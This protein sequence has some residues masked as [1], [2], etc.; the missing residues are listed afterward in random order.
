M[1]FEFDVHVCLVSAQPVPNLLPVI[2]PQLGPREKKVILLVS[3]EMKARADNLRRVLKSRGVTCEDIEFEDAYDYNTI[4]DKL[5]DCLAGYDENTR[6]VLNVTGG[7][8]IMTVAAQSVFDVAGRPMLYV[9]ESDSAVMMFTG[10]G[11][12]QEQTRLGTRL[13]L[14]EY[15]HAYGFDV[16]KS[17][18]PV[19][20]PDFARTL[21]SR[22]GE[23][24]RPLSVMNGIIA[25]G[26]RADRHQQEFVIEPDKLTELEDLITLCV[27][28]K[29]ARRLGRRLIFVNEA[30]LKF[31]SGGWLE[32]YV[33]QQLGAVGKGRVDDKALGLTITRHKAANELDVVFLAANR[34]HVVECK[35]GRL[36]EEKGGAVLYKLNSIRK[37]TGLN[38]RAM[39]VSYRAVDNSASARQHPHTDRARE[40]GIKVIQHE[41]LKSLK[42]HLETWI[43]EI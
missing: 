15:F 5:L 14:T 33:Y 9:R 36:A 23:F 35:T 3:R 19:D 22:P 6:I 11:G 12:P 20:R 21:I 30:A 24:D 41:Q 4:R 40:L 43:S 31:V 27:F 2:D 16:E 7:T 18:P 39:L 17:A 28:H 38:P 26:R 25:E 42:N 34:L 10:G 32:E 37:E 13:T 29:L 8:K 1:S